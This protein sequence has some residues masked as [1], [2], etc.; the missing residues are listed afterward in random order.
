MSECLM[1]LRC[2]EFAEL[3]TRGEPESKPNN[4]GLDS[5]ASPGRCPCLRCQRVWAAWCA[6]VVKLLAP[7]GG[8]AVDAAGTLSS[9]GPQAPAERARVCNRDRFGSSF[10]WIL[11]DNT[12]CDHVCESGRRP[13]HSRRCPW[14]PPLCR[15]LCLECRSDLG[16]KCE[17]TLRMTDEC[18]VRKLAHERISVTVPPL[19]SFRRL[20]R[21]ATDIALAQM[22]APDPHRVQHAPEGVQYRR[23][24][25][26]DFAR[27]DVMQ[28]CFSL[29][30]RYLHALQRGCH[31]AAALRTGSCCA[32]IVRI[33]STR[34]SRTRRLWYRSSMVA[35]L[36]R[37]RRA[38][39][40]NSVSL[41]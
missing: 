14:G 5:G 10:R 13:L 2:L 11:P 20:D 40:E 39:E 35:T 16:I 37:K 17:A 3:G 12:D 36:F 9:A 6:A 27:E 25:S 8:A 24:H 30:D 34:S 1:I 38:R 7:A 29:A 18:E 4:L 15:E 23:N 21:D 33:R 41:L 19:R 22:R 32:K 31:S 26:G 28:V